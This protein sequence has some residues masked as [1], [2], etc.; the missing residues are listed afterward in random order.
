[1]NIFEL[2]INEDIIKAESALGSAKSCDLIG[3]CRE[4]LACLSNYR[5][6][7]M[8]LK[9]IPAIDPAEPSPLKFELAGHIRQAVRKVLEDIAAKRNFYESLLSSFTNISG[10]DAVRTLNIS[11]FKGFDSWELFSG[12]ARLRYAPAEKGLTMEEAIN[13]A[14]LLRREAYSESKTTF[15]ERR[16]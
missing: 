5:D 15:F 12:G 9:D 14:S 16:F 6:Q 7:L 3:L 2:I 13:T 11:Q 1:M 10:Y 8:S 4:Y